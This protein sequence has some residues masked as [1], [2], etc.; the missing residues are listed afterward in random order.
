MNKSLMETFNELMETM[1]RFNDISLQIE[2]QNKSLIE[3][4][5]RLEKT[6]EEQWRKELY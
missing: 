2:K 5:N 3:I 1:N 6:V 4:N